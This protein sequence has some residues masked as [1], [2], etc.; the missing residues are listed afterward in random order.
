MSK[1]QIITVAN[2]KG[3]TA[4]TTTTITLG[5]ALSELGLRVLL[6]DFDPQGNL[7]MAAD[8]YNQVEQ[9]GHMTIHNLLSELINSKPLSDISEIQSTYIVSAKRFDII[10]ANIE[11]SVS[12]MN[13]RSVIGWEKSLSIILEPL[14]SYYDIILVDTN[15]SLG[16]LTISALTAADWVLIPVSPEFWSET[17]LNALLNSI[18][19]I[20]MFYNNHIKILGV[21]MT[22]CKDWTTLFKEIQTSLH[23]THDNSIRIFKQYIPEATKVGEGFIHNQ[24]IIDYCS[25]SKAAIAYSKFAL[26]V[27]EVMKDVG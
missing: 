25:S 8:V 13:L 21:L 10:P 22:R 9:E 24:C 26:E 17:G 11:L 1:G 14:K 6:I 3:G 12:E 27:T 16:D 15:P 7:S 19:R 2:Q 23:N 20:R 5:A 18:S 4:K